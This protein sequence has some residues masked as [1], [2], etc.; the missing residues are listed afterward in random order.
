MD[1]PLLFI[2][3][4]PTLFMFFMVAIPIFETFFFLETRSFYV[5]QIY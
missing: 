2:A 4:L 5:A 1:T 3:L